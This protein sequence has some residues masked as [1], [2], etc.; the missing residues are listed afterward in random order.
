MVKGIKAVTDIETVSVTH[1]T[2]IQ[3]A[4]AITLSAWGLSSS[5]GK[6]YNRRNSSGPKMKPILLI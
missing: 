1:Q 5:I 6:L 3:T 2:T 4:T